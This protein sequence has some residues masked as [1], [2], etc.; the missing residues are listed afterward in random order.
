[1]SVEPS[2]SHDEREQRKAR[3]EHGQV[4]LRGEI[5]RKQVA[6]HQMRL[7]QAQDGLVGRMPEGRPPLR[8]SG[9]DGGNESRVEHLPLRRV[10][11][12]IIGDQ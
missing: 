5:G 12:G 9:V 10:P 6:L 1:M 4:A 11:L 3:N 8:E 7:A 2:E